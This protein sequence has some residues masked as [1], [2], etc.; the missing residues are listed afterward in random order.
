MLFFG[1]HPYDSNIGTIGIGLGMF[2]TCIVY[3]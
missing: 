2:D 3:I 1:C